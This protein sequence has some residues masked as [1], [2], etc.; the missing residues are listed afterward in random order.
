MPLCA[1]GGFESYREAKLELFRRLPKYGFAVLNKED[2]SAEIFVESTPAEVFRYSRSAIEAEG[3]SHPAKV[4][5]SPSGEVILEIDGVV[6][7]S[8][9]KGEFNAMNILAAAATAMASGVPLPA[10]AKAVTDFQGVA[11]RMEYVQEAPFAVVVD[12]AHTPDA[13]ESV[14]QTLSSANPKPETRNPKLICVFGAAGGGRDK[15]K[16]PEMGRMAG[17][18]CQKIILTS[19]DPDDE[20][21]L[22][23]MEEIGRGFSSNPKSPRP[24]RGEAEGG[25]IPNYKKI[26]SRREAIRMALQDAQPGDT[27]IITGM[28]AQP[29]FVEKGKK[30]P[31]DDRQIVR[32]ELAKL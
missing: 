31:W 12:Y 22:Q 27:V 18:F 24:R 15:W 6:M 14:Y 23:I 26:E 29:W 19:E 9:L 7:P 8:R 20:N 28:G 32:E 5:F 30:I 1:H 13:L 21:P 11:G 16:R 4:A 10:I 17:R 3:I 25:Q 2:G